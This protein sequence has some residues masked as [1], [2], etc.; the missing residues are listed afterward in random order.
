M[1]ANRSP[2]GADP[3]SATILEYVTA[4]VPTPKVVSVYGP[5]RALPGV[6]SGST[7]ISNTVLPTP[8][9]ILN[10]VKGT[11]V[12]FVKVQRPPKVSPD[13]D[14]LK[15]PPATAC[16]APGPVVP[17][18]AFPDEPFEK[19]AVT[20]IPFIWLPEVEKPVSAVV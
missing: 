8:A 16:P 5:P 19:V 17:Q 2:N 10:P 4:I 3:L 6:S 9:S 20:C 14:K 13:S 7:I 11:F 12:R 18:V 15:T 1:I